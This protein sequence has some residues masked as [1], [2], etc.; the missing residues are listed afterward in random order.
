MKAKGLKRGQAMLEYVLVFC[1]LAI[2]STVF[3]YLLKG[4]DKS[5]DKTRRLVTSQ[6]P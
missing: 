4:I 1:A 5:S 6:Y 3:V 2:A